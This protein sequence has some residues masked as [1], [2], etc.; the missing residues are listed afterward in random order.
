[1]N[2]FAL[3]V[4][5]FYSADT[6][7][8]MRRTASF[9]MGYALVLVLLTTL[10]VCVY[11]G[12][13]FHRETFAARGNQP[14]P[15]SAFVQQITDQLPLMTFKDGVLQTADPVAHTIYLTGEWFG[16]S[17]E[18]VPFIM[19]D[20]TGTT[21]HE[22]MTTPILVNSKEI[23]I[24]KDGRNKKEIYSFS[25]IKD[26]APLTLIFNRAMN[27]DLAQQIIRWFDEN[28]LQMYL[29]FGG[30]GWLCIAIAIYVMRILMLLLLGV[31]G[32]AYASLTRRTLSYASAVSLASLSY[33]PVLLLDTFAFLFGHGPHSITLF[34]A[35]SVLLVIVI[36]ASEGA[37]PPPPSTPIV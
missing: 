23:A 9:G 22:N 20:T 33:T 36:R 28:L 16:E 17:F 4:G 24:H 26:G 13:L 31:V 11:F 14:S 29:I 6:Y 30:I 18:R 10:I 2:L 1:M 32:I 34:A 15:F 19:I 25:D 3:F 37:N 7:R 12:M 27:D 35:G 8:H 21:T 5:S